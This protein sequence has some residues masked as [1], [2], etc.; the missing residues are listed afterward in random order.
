MESYARWTTKEELINLLTKVNPKEEIKTSGIAMDYD[1]DNLY[2]D[3]TD[4]ATLVIG[5]QASGKTQAISLPLI[6]STCK[7]GESIIIND[8]G[9]NFY[10]NTSKEFI[11]NNYDVKVINFSDATKTNYYNPLTLPYLL[12]KEGNKD[13]ALELTKNLSYYIFRDE[14]DA[15]AFWINS[16]RDYFTGIILYLFEKA[17]EEEIN[18][19][20]VY[21]LSISLNENKKLLEEINSLDKTNSIY[22]YL[23]NIINAPKETKGGIVAT[24]TQHLTQYIAKENLSNMLSSNDIDLTSITKNKTAIY[25]INKPEQLSNTLASLLI[26]Q[27]IE[28]TIIYGKKERRLNILLDEFNNLVPICNLSNLINYTR[29]LNIRF[30]I[31]LNSYIELKNKYGEEE[32][33]LIKYSCSN[34]IYLLAKDDYTLEEISK[35]CGNQSSKLAL[36]TKEELR[37]LKMF[38]A[39]ILKTRVMPIKT[40][41]KPDYLI[42]WNSDF[43]ENKDYPHT[44][45]KEKNI[46]TYE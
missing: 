24:F 7:A 12:Y 34:I 17:K 15:D 25:I 20:S 5:G 18:L 45:L 2:L 11:N 36:I 13:K 16:S 37:T 40:K 4:A 30:T 19:S 43:S 29:S 3:T 41:L 14:E 21:S 22:I 27:L 46:Y 35:L 38:E 32:S 42:E 31:L 39:I 44:I 1:S 6:K 10:K 8:V 9:G 33:E 23:T 28:A 26:N